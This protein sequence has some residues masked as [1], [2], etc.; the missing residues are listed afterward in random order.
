[1]ATCF[2]PAR[3]QFVVNAV[4]AERERQDAKWGPQDHPLPVW[5]AIL[6]EEVGELS[7]CVLHAQFGGH[8]A[9]N[10][11]KEAV[12]VAAVALALVQ[13]FD[14]GRAWT[15]PA[16]GNST[17]GKP[18]PPTADP[19]GTL[20]VYPAIPGVRGPRTAIRKTDPEGT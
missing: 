5:M 17:A 3:M 13:A 10:L 6:M 7:E 8:A 18:T 9:E 14:E 20:V 15:L 11:R 12:Q 1:M 4:V 2:V 19:E 16:Q